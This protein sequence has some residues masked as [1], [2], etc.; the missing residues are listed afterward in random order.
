M[1]RSNAVASC[2]TV[3]RVCDASRSLMEG[4][5]P[6]IGRRGTPKDDGRRTGGLAGLF[7]LEQV[8]ERLSCVDLFAGHAAGPTSECDGLSRNAGTDVLE[9]RGP[10]LVREL[11]GDLEVCQDVPF[12]PH[13]QR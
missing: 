6:R 11:P 7:L 10:D 2:T 5:R 9:E 3:W 4:R 12:F 13:F 1:A 8:P